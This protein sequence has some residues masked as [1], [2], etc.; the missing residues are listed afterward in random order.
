[1]FYI[2]NFSRQIKYISIFVVL[3]L[4]I[5][6]VFFI[7]NASCT[8]TSD[9]TVTVLN[10]GSAKLQW[11]DNNS[12]EKGYR[13]FRKTDTGDFLLIANPPPNATEYYDGSIN[14]AHTYTYRVDVLDSS[15][16]LNAYTNEVSL[17][18]EDVVQPDSL[19]VTS[20]TSGSIELVWSYPAKKAYSTI[21]ERRADNDTN[22]YQL[23]KVANG[24]TTYSDKGIG[25]GAR[26]YYRVMA[27]SGDYVKSVA[28]PNDSIGKGAYSYLNK[29]TGLWG[30]A[31]SP[32]QIQLRWQD[33][34]N[35]TQF[36]LERRAPNE[37]VFKEVGP[38]P[39]NTVTY[40][41]NVPQKDVIY[42]YRIKAVTGAASSE[43]SDIASVASSYLRT[44]G[45]LTVACVDGQYNKLT[46][47][48]LSDGESEFEI[49]KKSVSAADWE[50]IATVARNNT[51]YIDTSIS[52]DTTYLYKVRANIYDNSVYSDFSN[53]AS[54]WT[55]KID[56]EQNLKYN[57]ISNNEVEL[58]WDASSL[59]SGYILEKKTG[60]DGQWYDVKSITPTV[61][62]YT[63]KNYNSNYIYYYRLRAYDSSNAVS[64]SNEVAV[65]IAVPEAATG[66]TAKA[67]SSSEVQL[68]WKDNCSFE[69]QYIIEAKSYFS[70]KEIARVPGN[71]TT[72]IQTNIS[73]E[74]SILYRVRSVNGTILGGYSN[75]AMVVTKKKVTYKDVTTNDV[76]YKAIN[77]LASRGAFNAAANTYFKPSENITRGEFC[78]ILVRSLELNITAAGRFADLNSNHSYYKDIMSA[79]KLGI[80]QA[81]KNNKINPND[82][83][84][85]EQALVLI[86]RALKA[87]GSP[88]PEQNKNILKQ[89][90]DYNTVSEYA[91]ATIASICG[92]NI[93]SGSTAGGRRYLK[94]TGNVSRAEAALYIYNAV[95]FN[96]EDKS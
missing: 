84:T 6:S 48:D 17:S 23:A 35:E 11:V 72:Y 32:Y 41:D 85:K 94:I 12:D 24:I 42:A 10:T 21:I 46:W 5:Q 39:Q 19:T 13:V 96:M 36:I 82:P 20:S 47:Q 81:D 63:D 58:N 70:Y 9:L 43:Y 75:E 59:Y 93:Y 76:A 51:S 1:M 80:I 4:I 74:S 22:W 57:I 71:T 66:L 33:N 27:A 86:A 61:Q 56:A 25:P 92:S 65:S 78:S 18:T 95:Q 30:F 60:F 15:N 16:V 45:S 3:T 79:A 37:G 44:P 87:A 2:K 50:R 28:F 49:W 83:V 54:I 38:I 62:K 34:S 89:Y 91:Q 73:P 8:S 90:A 7:G 64:Y 68:K 14:I 26:Y 69:S 53:E 55:S 77:N 29:P 31:V 40:I 52:T 67:L 88:L